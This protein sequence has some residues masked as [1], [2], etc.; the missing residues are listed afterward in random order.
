MAKFDVFNGDADGLC[1]LQQLRLASPEPD[2]QL[3]TGVKRDI[4]LLKKVEAGANDRITVLDISLDKNISALQPLLEA[5]ASVEYFDHHFPGEAIPQHTNFIAHINTQPDTCTSLIVNAHLDSQHWRWAATG[6]FGDNFDQ[7][8]LKLIK[9]QDTRLSESEISLLKNL[10]TYINYNAYGES[11]SDLHI[12]PTDLFRALHPYTN[13]LDFIAS[14]ST[15]QKLE[16]G[17]QEDMTKATSLTAEF[18]TSQHAL[19]VLPTESWA[20]RVSGVYA[21]DLAQNHP[22]RAHA[23]LTH[24]KHGGYL[25]SVRAPLNTK[26]G[27]DDLCRQFESGGGRKAAAGINL[28]PEADLSRFIAAFKAA[29]P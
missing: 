25:V 8:A 1:A 4:S 15:Y 22:Q 10:G 3:I 16:H 12:P 17:Y 9:E 19:F 26:S 21:N 18:A 20:R 5:G 7:S 24:L 29:Y 14:D 6:A 2:A 28:L 11:V 23:L 27:A 13:P